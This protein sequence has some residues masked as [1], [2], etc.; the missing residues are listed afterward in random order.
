MGHSPNVLWSP[1]TSGASDQGFHYA[2]K[3]GLSVSISFCDTHGWGLGIIASQCLAFHALSLVAPAHPL[4]VPAPGSTSF[5]VGWSV[6]F[7]TGCNWEGVNTL[8]AV[9]ESKLSICHSSWMLKPS[10]QPTRH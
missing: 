2:R 4:Y 3:A 9:E 7:S 10:T 5:V 1:W 6:H 8:L